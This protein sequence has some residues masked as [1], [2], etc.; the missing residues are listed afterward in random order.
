MEKGL[1]Q[2]FFL[3]IQFDRIDHDPVAAGRRLATFH[4]HH[5]A[6]VSSRYTLGW[7]VPAG[8]VEAFGPL[9]SLAVFEQ[10]A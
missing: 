6:Y 10:A 8:P 7:P 1:D 2:V 3:V 5:L 9:P 4:E